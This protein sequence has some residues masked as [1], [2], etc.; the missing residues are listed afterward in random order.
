[1][2]LLATFYVISK[3]AT[4]TKCPSTI[5]YNVILYHNEEQSMA[6]EIRPKSIYFMFAFHK[7]H[8]QIKLHCSIV[9]YKGAYLS[10]KTNKKRKEKR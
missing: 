9:V 8:K 1:M 6:R 10:D 5:V 7:F 2:C 4:Q 3:N